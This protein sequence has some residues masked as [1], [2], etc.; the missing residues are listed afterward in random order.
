MLGVLSHPIR[1]WAI[2]F[3]RKPARDLQLPGLMESVRGLAGGRWLPS[4]SDSQAVML[5]PHGAAGEVVH[6][7]ASI[8]SQTPGLATAGLCDQT[9]DRAH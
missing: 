6:L 8:C 9:A 4:A 1:V 7:G 3:L 5:C 2:L